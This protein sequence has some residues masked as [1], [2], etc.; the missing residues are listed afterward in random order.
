M[1]SRNGTCSYVGDVLYVSSEVPSLSKAV[2]CD[3]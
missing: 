3:F 1:L 2:F